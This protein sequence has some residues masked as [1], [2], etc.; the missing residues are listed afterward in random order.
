MPVIKPEGLMQSAVAFSGWLSS[1][2]VASDTTVK[3]GAGTVHTATFSCAD[4]APTAGTIAILDHTGAGGGT[5]LFEHNF[6]TTP[7][8]PF[9]VTL[10]MEFTAGLVID[11]TTTGD[12]NV[13]LSY[14]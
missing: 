1:G 9:T 14:R 7:F 11:C 10:D 5:K 8:V 2:S 6:T 4:A 3:T 12:V 13:T